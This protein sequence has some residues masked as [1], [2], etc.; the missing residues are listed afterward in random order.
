LN[1]YF[2]DEIEKLITKDATVF[3]FRR[4]LRIDDNAGLYHALKSATE[5][6]CLF[7]FDSV[8]LQK[9]DD[10]KDKR[11]DFIYRSLELLKHELEESGSTLI[12]V[13]GNPLDIFKKI[14]PKAVYTNHDYEPYALA[15]DNS[16]KTILNAKGVAFHTFKDQV[17]FDK[18]EI[19]KDNG[20]P[21]TVFTPYSKKWKATVTDFFVKAYPSKKLK[22]NLLQTQ[23]VFFPSLNDIGFEKT[24][25]D[26][27]ERI[28]KTSL[29]KNYHHTRDF[30]AINGT[31]RLS[32][33][34]RFGTVSIRKLASVALK[35]NQTWLNELIWRDFYHMILWHFPQVQH[36]S[37]KPAYDLIRWRNDEAEFQRWC[38]GTTGYPIVDAGM[39]ELNETGFMHN[40]VRMITAS[41]LTKHL[42]IDWRW[43]EAY[44][45]K[46]LL[47]YDLAPNNGG[48][49]WAAGSGCDAVP[50]FRVF[51]PELQTEKFDPELKYIHRWIPEFGST[52][53]PKPIVDHKFAR[54]RAIKTYQHAL[55]KEH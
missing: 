8:I 7:I 1:K 47:D 16:V 38:D 55:K 36:K 48:W 40:R 26:A 14:N 20:S 37:F 49:Q 19:V 17:I 15:R 25:L 51:N 29:I 52:A 21:Y 45:A 44:F 53:Y 42:L 23:P 18:N 41:F 27:P 35:E 39:R 24:D 11:V 13:Y 30:P 43:G 46:K 32:L 50:Y 6:V 10:K 4:D 3:W 33:H 9:L 2:P 12:T 5:V 22:K 28:I 31:T 34:L 54:E